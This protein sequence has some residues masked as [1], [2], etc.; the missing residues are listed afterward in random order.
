MKV[1]SGPTLL[2]HSGDIY[3]A[4]ITGGRLGVFQ[5]GEYPMIWSYLRVDCLEHTNHGLHFDGVDDYVHLDD[6]VTIGLENRYH[7]L[8]S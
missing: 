1:Y 8:H 6:A 3:D 4:T 2:V 5:F 7:T